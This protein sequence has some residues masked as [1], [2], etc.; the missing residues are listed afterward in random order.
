VKLFGFEITWAKALRL[1]ALSP[2][3]NRGGWWP[4]VRES[5]V[6]A[7]QQNVEI[8]TDTVL[9]Y[10]AV[11]SCISR[12][13]ADV[14][15][16]RIK[17]MAQDGDGI[18]SEVQNPAFSPVLRKPNRYQTRIKFFEQ[19]IT[20]KLIFGNAYVLKAR[21]NRNVVSALYVLD[22]NRVTPLVA[23]DGSVF[24]QLK[25]DDLAQIT[26]EFVAENPAIPAS[27]IIHDTMVTLFHPLVGVSPIYAC[28]LAAIQG[29]RIQTNSA[30]FF[31]NGARP[32]GILTAPGEISNDTAARLKNQWET[33]YGGTNYGRVA[34]LGDGLKFEAMVMTAEDSQLIEQ[35]KWSA[36]TVAACF[37][38]PPFVIGIGTFPDNPEKAMIN[39]YTQ[40]LQK[41]I[42]AIE[43]LL[44]EGL[45]LPRP[46]GTEFDLDGL[47][48]M[49]T[50]SL[51]DTIGKGIGASLLTPNEGRFRLDLKPLDGGDTAYMQQQNFSLQA[52]AER[53]R[54][55]PFSKAAPAAPAA[56]AQPA[57]DNAAAAQAAAFEAL[58]LMRRELAL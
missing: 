19:W 34:V 7:W 16:L 49:D 32:S 53:D 58:Y 40:C 36:E 54:N 52:L 41:L 38:V 44:D 18:W 45:E 33:N 30:Q 9:T 15:K 29:V 46:F 56:D 28:G 6:G 31:G 24:Y 48:R 21:D 12:I 4:R 50:A 1:P 20:S 17:L 2:V 22:P 35:L 42:E 27:E 3:D 39:Y 55:Q 47:L 10:S 43:I 13:A 23:P 37:H 5:F 25:R 26:D 51:Y 57:N 14:G 8:R 11:Y